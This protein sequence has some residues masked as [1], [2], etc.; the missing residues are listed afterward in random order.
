M[1]QEKQN[2]GI[3]QLF[4]S[5][6]IVFILLMLFIITIPGT[7]LY[8]QYAVPYFE[9]RDKKQAE[10][11]QAWVANKSEVLA[12]EAA[13]KVENGVHL[14]SGLVADTHYQLVVQN[15]TSC[16]SAKLI[17]QNRADKSGWLAMIKWMQAEQ[18]L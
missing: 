9:T 4:S 7:I 5:L 8:F 3:N 11:N 6:G 1:E 18:K 10:G 15:C 16:H 14:A 17:T 13:E 2:K 12:K